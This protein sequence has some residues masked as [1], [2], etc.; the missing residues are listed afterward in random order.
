VETVVPI[1]IAQLTKLVEVVELAAL[2]S[3]EHQQQ[4]TLMALQVELEFLPQ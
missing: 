2:E 1:Q 4:L 3:L